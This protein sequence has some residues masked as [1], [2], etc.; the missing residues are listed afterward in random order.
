M[1][2]E[3]RFSWSSALP[4]QARDVF[5]WHARPGA[6]VRLNDPW[7]P[8]TIVEASNSI[9]QGAKVS[10]R[11]PVLGPFGIRWHLQHTSCIPDQEFIDQQL[12]GP[13][14]SW[15]HAHRFVA[16]GTSSVMRDDIEYLLPRGCAI[17]EPLVRR[18]LTRLFSFRHALLRSDLDLHARWSDKPRKKIVLAGAS[19]FVGTALEAF[20]TTA[21]H[22]VVR[23]VRR[24]PRALHERMW[25]P[26]RGILDPGTFEG[27]HVLINLAGENI[28]AGRWTPAR[29]RAIESSRVD[30]AR[31]LA[32][33][34]S[35]LEK[36]L[37]VVVGASGVGC[38]G[39][40]GENLVDE[41]APQAHGFL[42]RVCQQWEDAY[43]VPLGKS[44]DTRLVLLRL[45]TV[46]NARGGALQKM[47][48][49][50]V[51]C[52][53]GPL[54]TGRQWMSWIAMQDLLG[55]VEHA[56]YTSGLQGV[57]NCVAPQAVRNIDF[58]K[59]LAG[60]LSR[61]A[62][63]KAPARI[64]SLVFGD[65]MAHTLLLANSRVAPSKLEATC[66]R[67]VLPDLEQALRFEC[68]QLRPPFSA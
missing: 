2:P 68:A 27:A 3:L 22:E 20:L 5:A 55:I 43:M 38:Y 66:Y 8:V 48:P 67:F 46:L 12:R 64:L 50:F 59:T 42:S 16:D 30:T 40:T 58:T 62:V 61:P 37:E 53:G 17:A 15:R 35:K 28:A 41:A 65:E 57:V 51:A 10:I 4:Y 31:L 54:G 6:F 60:V 44:A 7:R 9:A 33:V 11:V 47:L 1:A 19:G 24:E 26:A 21:G 25:D 45:G 29:K 63:L 18:E 34:V 52:L 32:S 49:A 14:R 23:L 36:P 13:F 39:D 56:I